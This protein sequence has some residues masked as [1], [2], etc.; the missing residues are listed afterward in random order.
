MDKMLSKRN[1]LIP[2][3]S[4]SSPFLVLL[5]AFIYC[6]V[7]PS[8]NSFYLLALVMI[9][10]SFN[11]FMKNAVMKPLYKLSGK[12]DIFLFGLGYRP[13]GATSCSLHLDG[14]PSTS[15]GM[16]SG[17]SQMI[18][19]IGTFILCKIIRKLLDKLNSNDNSTAL[20]NSMFYIWI[21]I[22]IV[23]ILTSMF[24]VSYSRVYIEGCHTLQQIIMGGFIGAVIGFLGYYYEDIIITKIKSIY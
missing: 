16:P 5:G 12:R 2:T 23:S 24:Y 15:F 13:T 1:E 18:W 9:N 6:I 11:F 10:S 20:E 4:R 14:K 22:S 19:M 17:H 21:G 7:S 3:V 8:Y